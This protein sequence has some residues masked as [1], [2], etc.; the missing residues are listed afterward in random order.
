MTANGMEPLLEFG[1]SLTDTFNAIVSYDS[2]HPNSSESVAAVATL[3]QFGTTLANGLAT[4][5]PFAQLLLTVTGSQAALLALTTTASEFQLALTTYQ[6]NPNDANFNMVLQRGAGLVAAGGGL[7]STL[8]IPQVRLAGLAI[9]FSAIGAQNALN[10]NLSNLGEILGNEIYELLNPSENGGDLTIRQYST[11]SSE[12][13]TFELLG[14]SG[15]GYGEVGLISG[16]ATDEWV[17]EGTVQVLGQD[18]SGNEIVLQSWTDAGYWLSNSSVTEINSTTFNLS[19]SGFLDAYWAL[20]DAADFAGNTLDFAQSVTNSAGITGNYLAP[21]SLLDV[22]THVNDFFSEYNWFEYLD[23]LPIDPV[24]ETYLN[25]NFNPNGYGWDTVTVGYAQ[26]YYGLQYLLGETNQYVQGA[27]S[28]LP[29][30]D[31]VE[32]L[33]SDFNA[34]GSPIAIDLD[35]DGVETVS[36]G[37]SGVDFD[38]TGDGVA[39][40]TGWLSPDDAFLVMDRNGNKKI[41]GVSEMFGGL[42]RGDGFAELALLDS[43]GDG[44]IN[45]KDK[46]FSSLRLWQDKNSNGT[47]DKG[48]LLKLKSL[49]ITELSLD[50]AKSEYIENGNLFGEVS[51]AIVNGDEHDM[52][53]VYFRY[54]QLP[55]S[56]N[57]TPEEY[58][59][60]ISESALNFNWTMKVAQSP[61]TSGIGDGVDGKLENLVAAMASFAPPA[62]GQTTLPQNYQD[63]L[64]GVIAAN[65]Q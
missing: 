3:V 42:N 63:A 33:E 32:S 56:P 7:L 34:N 64:A 65:W 27:W 31:Y 21:N 26:A 60:N 10:G 57:K 28:R 44:V 16:Q 36:I 62:A 2:Q 52:V 54:H 41:D 55:S 5:S 6:N 37:Q 24:I 13:L 47:T 12:F 29:L 9:Q 1:N 30:T 8:P 53:D 22:S 46:S 38:I 45:K 19:S 20:F 50:Y 18:A 11:G 61:T 25:P 48:E 35:G 14:Q 23:P 51:H 15:I 17:P 40:R 39:E 59:S 49:G 43:N 4:N 58:D